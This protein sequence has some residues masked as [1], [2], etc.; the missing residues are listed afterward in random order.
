MLQIVE[1]MISVV[2]GFE[3]LKG[4]LAFHLSPTEMLTEL[5]LID[6]VFILGFGLQRP[7]GPGNA[8]QSIPLST[9]FLGQSH[10]F[11]LIKGACKNANGAAGATAIAAGERKWVPLQLK[12]AQDV[13]TFGDV[14][15]DGAIFLAPVNGDPVPGSHAGLLES[16]C[17][18]RTC[19]T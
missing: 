17:Y 12:T 14:V 4:D 19:P 10:R 2:P 6:L 7:G 11:P 18:I 3:F 16:P 15:A 9:Q 8:E 13:I 1:D 5:E